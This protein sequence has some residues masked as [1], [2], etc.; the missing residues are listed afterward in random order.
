MVH[1]RLQR[2]AEFHDH[3]FTDDF[4]AEASRFYAVASKSK[5]LYRKRVLHACEGLDVLEYGC[6]PGSC[7]FDL[8]RRGAHVTGIDISPGAIELARAQAA[9]EGLEQQIEFEV[10]NAEALPLADHRFDRICGSGILHHLDVTRALAEI[11][12]VL[13]PDGDAVFFEPLGHNPLINWYRRRT[14]AMRTVDEHPLMASDLRLLA[15][16]FGRNRF[17]YHHL[18]SLAAAMWDGRPGFGLLTGLLGALDRCVLTLPWIRRQAWIVI[19]E[20]E[21]PREGS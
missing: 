7:A 16:G 2:E 11:Q 4:R 8:A 17:S 14:P 19:A 5:G 20:L 13:R 3:V 1:T 21:E 9:S 18:I 12:R 10:M 6:G 15:A